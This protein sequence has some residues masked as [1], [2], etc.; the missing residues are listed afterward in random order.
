MVRGPG[1]ETILVTE[2][3][4]TVPYPATHDLRELAPVLGAAIPARPNGPLVDILRPR[5]PEESRPQTIS[6]VVGL[7]RFPFH[8]D[9]AY[10]R[11]P[12]RY[13][14]LRLAAGARSNTPTL[15]QDF[16]QLPFSSV[17]C[18]LL[19]RAV[20]AVSGGGKTFYSGVISDTSVP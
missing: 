5:T 17:E 10:R 18:S 4:A 8:P 15:L 6:A 13:L 3:W 1:W 7:H 12:P 9:Q 16:S 14:L 2:G 20:W 11:V 19:K